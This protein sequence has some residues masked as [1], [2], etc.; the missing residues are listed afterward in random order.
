MSSRKDVQLE[1]DKFNQQFPNLAPVYTQSVNSSLSLT[2]D[3]DGNVS[4]IQKI[5]DGITIN[6]TLT[7]TDG[8][9]TAVS[10]WEEV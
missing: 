7:W 2:Y 4:Q 3:S 1:H 6:K 10:A 5:V 8:V 9:L